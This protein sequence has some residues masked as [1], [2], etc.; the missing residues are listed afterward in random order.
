M[1]TV[2][3]QQ[4]N[5]IITPHLIKLWEVTDS[6]WVRHL[7][8]TTHFRLIVLVMLHFHICK[9]F[10]STQIKISSLSQNWMMK[11]KTTIV[12]RKSI[13]AG[14]ESMQSA[15]TM[16]NTRIS[17]R[18]F[19]NSRTQSRPQLLISRKSINII[20]YRLLWV[21]FRIRATIGSSTLSH[22]KLV[23]NMLMLSQRVLSIVQLKPLI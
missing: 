1:C 2:I 17:I 18:M 8:I 16:T 3:N 15:G 13:I 9:P 20:W 23:K 14:L 5:R 19:R 7:W 4:I 12:M 22:S 10:N 21:W 11:M 6:Q